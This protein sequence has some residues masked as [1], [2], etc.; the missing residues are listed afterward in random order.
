[1]DLLEAFDA[2]DVIAE[3]AELTEG[4]SKW[5]SINLDLFESGEN[6]ALYITAPHGQLRPADI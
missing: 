5:K 3:S 2:L 6:N 1:M 4:T